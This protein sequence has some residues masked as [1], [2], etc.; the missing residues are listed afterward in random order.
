MEAGANLVLDAGDIERAAVI[1]TEAVE[2]ATAAGERHL[3]ARIETYVAFI[4]LILDPGFG[5]AGVLEVADRAEPVLREAADHHGLAKVHDARAYVFDMLH[6]AANVEREAELAIAHARSAGS[7]FHELE[8]HWWL[9][10]QLPQGPRPVEDAIRRCH[11][12]R[13]EI[14]DDPAAEAAFLESLGEL[15]AMRGRFEEARM[16]A[17]ASI[18]KREELGLHMLQTKM[19]LRLGAIELLAG[20]PQAA[21]EVFREAHDEQARRGDVE[22]AAHAA[23]LLIEALLV[24]DRLADA[25][26]LLPAAQQAEAGDAVA[27]QVRSRCARAKILVR[28][29]DVASA[30]ALARHAV[31]LTRDT[32]DLNLQGAALTALAEVLTAGDRS[33]EARAAAEDALQLY[34][35]K[36]NLV[37]ADTARTFLATQ[38]S[39]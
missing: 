2:E 22:T 12:L 36:G 20:N 24:Q 13:A 4:R 9:F 34:E 11:E 26:A 19:Q 28:K 6:Q 21:E 18:A 39:L 29:G 14:Q 25:E 1:F 31:A 35:R 8:L 7:R 37:L 10:W 17:R 38:V 33:A 32:D 5:A 16:H 23:S 27:P 30:E 15:E 3:A